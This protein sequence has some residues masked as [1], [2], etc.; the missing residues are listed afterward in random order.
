MIS[1]INVF[2][3]FDYTAFFSQ[4]LLH[5][6]LPVLEYNIIRK[7]KKS[8]K[9]R[10]R[11]VADEKNFSM[12]LVIKKGTAESLRIYPSS[13]YQTTVIPSL[14]GKSDLDFSNDF[15]IQTKQV[16]LKK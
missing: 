4:Y 9:L 11:W 13:D 10:Y 7:D 8:I 14:N 15:Y 5:T 2:T 1:Y 6:E 12:P 16:N 3:G